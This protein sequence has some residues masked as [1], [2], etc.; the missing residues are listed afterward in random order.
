MTTERLIV[1]ARRDEDVPTLAAVLVRVHAVDA[2]PVEGVADPEAWLRHPR[3]LRSWV[4]EVDGRPVGQ[5]IL[6]STRPD[7]DAARLWREDTGADIADL[8]ILARLFVDPD[9][10]RVGAGQLLVRA[11]FDHAHAH[12]NAVAFDVMAKDR[13]A[14]RLYERLGARRLGTTVHHHSDGLTEPAVVYVAE[15]DLFRQ[16]A[17]RHVILSR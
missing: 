15:T 3:E 4:A 2:Y 13:A 17:S 16:R 11:A 14:I 1:R 9:H 8:V 12:G 7:D 10:R 5:V 6:T